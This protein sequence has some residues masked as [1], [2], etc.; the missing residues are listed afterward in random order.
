MIKVLI[1]LALICYSS[2]PTY[3]SGEDLPPELQSL[4]F[5]NSS[6][7][8][9]DEIKGKAPKSNA[10]VNTIIPFIQSS[11]PKSTVKTI[12]RNLA[13]PEQ[14]FCYHVT[15]KPANYTGYTIDNFAIIDYCG[16]LDVSQTVTTYEALFAQSPNIITA[17]SSCSI[18]PQVML[19]FIR[20]I[21]T[22]D[23]L[24]SSPCPS[25]TI[26]YAGRLNSFN[27]KQGVIDDIIAQFADNRQDF[28]SPAFI[29]QTQANG[30]PTSD[31]EAEK[32]EKQRRDSE[33]VMSWQK[34]TP[35]ETS[36]KPKPNKGWGHIKLNM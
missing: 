28:Y 36:E 24:L 25:F 12:T 7:P 1:A 26:F 16:E 23:V 35:K 17:R 29:K 9:T 30:K 6:L 18:E 32:Y 15:K 27:I 2:T 3:A 33:P 10:R 14:I 19:R 34:S 21:D 8:I 4:D 13:E 11:L 5:L 20:G 22:T 31:Q